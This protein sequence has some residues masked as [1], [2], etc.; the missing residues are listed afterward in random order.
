MVS[1]SQYA[2]KY[3]YDIFD[4][5]VDFGVIRDADCE[6]DIHFKIQDGGQLFDQII[7]M[8]VDFEVFGDFVHEI[9]INF[10]IRD[11]GYVLCML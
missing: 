10:Y 9:D 5:G 4:T 8:D 7:D 2:N 1:I 6:Y 3:F 11:D